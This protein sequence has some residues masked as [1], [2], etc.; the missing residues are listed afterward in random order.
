MKVENQSKLNPGRIGL[1]NFELS[2][3][4]NEDGICLW[5]LVNVEKIKILGISSAIDLLLLVF[6]YI[7][8]KDSKKG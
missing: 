2:T 3:K 6:R 1:T 8:N 7:H 4:D 5:R